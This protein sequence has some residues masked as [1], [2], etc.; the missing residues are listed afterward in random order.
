[1]IRLRKILN[2]IL[3]KEG[4]A[5]GHMAHPFDTEINLTF[6]QLKDI[7]NRALDGNLELSREKCIAGHTV[8]TTETNGKIT[9]AEFVD[10]GI[11]DKVLSFNE[12]TGNDEFMEVIAS[13][14]NDTTDEWLEIELEDGKT[15]QVTPNHR[16]YV[17]GV[18]Y[19][20]AKDLTE[21]MELKIS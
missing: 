1:M 14:N 12:E 9:I 2:E 19:I 13:F 18:G 17:E 4:G 15:I 3:L 8:I 11:S 5:Y 7:V 21:S 10:S 20:E 6:G 16:M